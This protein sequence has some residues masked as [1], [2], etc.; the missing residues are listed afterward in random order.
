MRTNHPITGLG[1]FCADHFNTIQDLNK[2]EIVF[3]NLQQ[4]VLIGRN[5]CPRGGAT[6]GVPVHL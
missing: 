6:L 4:T 2:H 5:M 1:G 3:H